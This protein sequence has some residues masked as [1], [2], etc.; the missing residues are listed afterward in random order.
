MFF[1][2]NAAFYLLAASSIGFLLL[3]QAF[4]TERMVI[5]KFFLIFA[6]L[7]GFLF[8]NNIFW[9]ACII[10]IGLF[11]ALNKTAS[12]P[13]LYIFLLLTTP[14]VSK[15]VKAGG[16]YLVDLNFLHCLSL[17]M[18]FAMLLGKRS[19][20]RASTGV[21]ICA[22]AV[23]LLFTIAGMRDGSATNALRELLNAALTFALPYYVLSRSARNAD[24]LRSIFLGIGCAMAVLSA[25]AVLETWRSWPIY[26]GIWQHYGIDLT[27]GASV[28]LRGGMMRSAG[29]YPEPL[30]FSFVLTLA[31][32]ALLLMRRSFV[33]NM[34]YW[35][36]LALCVAGIIMPQGR[37]AWLG[38]LIAVL[39][40]DIFKRDYRT[41]SIKAAL[42]GVAGCVVLLVSSF[43][44][45]IAVLLG[46]T[47]EGQGTVDYRQ[48]LLTR[49]MEEF[50]KHPLFGDSIGNVLKRMEDLIQGEGIVDLVNGYL[51][52]AL[53]SGGVGLAI[54]V[55]VILAV[56]ALL[57]GR[58]KM[59]TRANAD[60]VMQSLTWAFSSLVAIIVMLTAMSV[61]GP[62]FQM[63]IL[64]LAIAAAAISVSKKR[65][66][67]NL[68]M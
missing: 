26:R 57:V 39:A 36:L 35:P 19:A 45:N 61:V 18:L 13:G 27:S 46:L 2:I 16:T 53:I 30:S 59:A 28:K 63:L 51:H 7:T 48:R 40:I 58:R 10:I 20:R 29:P 3:H 12:L 62:P 44:H 32:L 52:I 64:V 37:T 15:P 42:L 68:D 67:P 23:I 41:F 14:I 5:R 33:T 17:G 24:D 47:A 8:V 22:T 21:D 31:F 56:A 66:I 50:W 9:L 49:G 65:K 54:F 60:I 4:P 25:I 1:Q 38:L 11:V 55:L 34:Q 6:V 43:N